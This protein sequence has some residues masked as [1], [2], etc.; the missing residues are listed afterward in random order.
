MAS[1]CSASISLT[2]IIVFKAQVNGLIAL[3]AIGVF[4]GFTLAGAGMVSSPS[5][6]SESGKWR[7]GACGQRSLRAR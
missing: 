7:F 4:T 2:L 1:S 5:A 3:Y 6:T